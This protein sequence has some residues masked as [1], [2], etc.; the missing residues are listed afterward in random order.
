M[1]RLLVVI[2][3]L[4]LV[5]SSTLAWGL[6]P[7]FNP[8]DVL[9]AVDLNDIVAI[10]N[11]LRGETPHTLTVDCAAGNTIGQALQQAVRGDTLQVTGTCREAV[12]ITID[13]L[14]LDGQ[15]TTTVDGGGQT[16]IT[17]N[18]A[19]R[20]VIKNLTVSNGLDGILVQRTAA[21]ELQSV[22]AQNNTRDGI[23]LNENSTARLTNCTMQQN[24]Q[25]GLDVLRNSSAV[26]SG[27]I[28]SNDNGR[29]GLHISAS[30][31]ASDFGTATTIIA[32]NNTNDGIAVLLHSS[33]L[34]GTSGTTLTVHRNLHRGVNLTATSHFFLGTGTA[35]MAS[36]N[37]TTGQFSGGIGVS[38]GAVFNA[39]AA[40][41]G[42]TLIVQDNLD[43]GIVVFD[44]GELKVGAGTTTIQRNTIGLAVTGGARVVFQ[45]ATVAAVISNNTSDGIQISEHASAQ[46]IGP[47][48]GSIQVMNNTGKG[49]QVDDSSLRLQNASLTGNGDI[50]LGASFGARLDLNAGNVM[51]TCSL[52]SSI[53]IRGSTTLP[54]LG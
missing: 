38:D 49:I 1:K 9:H 48:A 23:H 22:T 13:G 11:A 35:L 43:R 5:G 42:A 27:T 44:A 29:D 25:D 24:G 7:Q 45:G 34:A 20:V 15:G 16:A 39:Q 10:V 46:L 26:L 18:G 31:H 14:T 36:T 6:L 30:S 47:A 50:D 41:N 3:I 40:G 37:G 19:R 4:S 17:V 54:C 21:V 52:D 12:V 53:L 33:F 28:M 32:N 51:G 8:G 2:A